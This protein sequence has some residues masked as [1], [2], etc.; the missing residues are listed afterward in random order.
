V[1]HSEASVRGGDGSMRATGGVR[2]AAVSV[3]V[4]GK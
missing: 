2:N 1:R 3:L 4:Q